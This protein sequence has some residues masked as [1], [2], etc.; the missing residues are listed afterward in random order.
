MFTVKITYQNRVL[1][2]VYFA[3]ECLART[4]IEGALETL[5]LLNNKELEIFIEN[6]LD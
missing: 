5:K 4:Y 2:Q 6:D 1:K 3:D